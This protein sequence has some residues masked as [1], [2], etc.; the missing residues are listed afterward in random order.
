MQTP[1]LYNGGMEVDAMTLVE[2][3]AKEA[4]ELPVHAQQQVLSFIQFVKQKESQHFIA[5]VDDLISKNL[6]ALKELAE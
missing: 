3:I 2:R 5:E 1:V 4:Q 6:P